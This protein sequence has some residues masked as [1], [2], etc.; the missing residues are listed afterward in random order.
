[1]EKERYGE[2]IRIARIANDLSAKE[3][4]QLVG[5]SATIISNLEHNKSRVSFDT[6]KK[7][8]KAL[9]LRPHQLMELVEKYSELKEEDRLKRYQITLCDALTILIEN[10]KSQ[11]LKREED[12]IS[13]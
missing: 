8:S 12:E 9:N 6:F 2:V 11:D 5:K 1:M 3:L 13:K 4:A 10:K 7:I